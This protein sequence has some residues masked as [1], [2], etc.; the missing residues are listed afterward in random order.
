MGKR[1][2]VSSA[3]YWDFGANPIFRGKYI[4][5][6]RGDILDKKTGELENKIIGFV[7]HDE[8]GEQFLITNAWAIQKALNSE[9]ER[10]GCLVKDSDLWIEI[11]FI[12]KVNNGKNQPFNR[13]KVSVED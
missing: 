1:I 3:Q 7:M 13:F 6:Q 12:E 10:T 9:D 4:S 11:E 2:I 8:D 5:E